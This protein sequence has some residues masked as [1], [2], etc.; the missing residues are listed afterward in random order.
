MEKN[1][2]H[3]RTYRKKEAPKEEDD[4][5]PFTGEEQRAIVAPLPDQAANTIQF[6]FWAGLRT[7]ELVALDLSS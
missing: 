4:V 5:D 2:L 1:L 6:A 3:G 7:S